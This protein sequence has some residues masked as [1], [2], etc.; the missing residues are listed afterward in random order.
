LD[1]AKGYVRSQKTERKGE[2]GLKKK[3]KPGGKPNNCAQAKAKSKTRTRWGKKNV[4]ISAYPFRK[5]GQVKARTKK[6]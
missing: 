6:R 5:K 1:Q 4:K 3:K 2:K